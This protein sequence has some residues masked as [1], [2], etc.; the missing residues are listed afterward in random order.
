MSVYVSES[1]FSTL[2]GRYRGGGF[3]GRMV[4]DVPLFEKQSNK[5]KFLRCD[6]FLTLSTIVVS[7]IYV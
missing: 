4:N 6:E 5:S 7:E 1:L 3:L 2:L